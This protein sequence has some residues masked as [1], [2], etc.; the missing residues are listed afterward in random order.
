VIT[1]GLTGGIASGKS[2]VAAMLRR[3]GAH[4][5]DAD[6][7]ARD[8]VAP[9]TPALAEIAAQFGPAVL[10]PDGSLDRAAMAGRVFGDPAARA[11]LNAITHPRIR[12]EIVARIEALRASARAA[13]VVVDIPLLLDTASPD[14]YGLDGVLVVFADDGTRLARLRARDGL[15]EPEARAR[16]NAQRPLR[17]KLAGATWIVD[18][19]GTIEDTLRQVEALWKTWTG[20]AGPQ[21]A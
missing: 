19:S 8:V 2:T 16:F 6:L 13:V 18:N 9:G 11:A 7:I 1:I 15:S 20:G 10:R 5:I 21:Q 4:L 3:I 12:A 17:E 14:I